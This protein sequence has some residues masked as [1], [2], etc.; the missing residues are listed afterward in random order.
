MVKR[1]QLSLLLPFIALSSFSQTQNPAN[2]SDASALL[3]KVSERYKAYK[4]VTAEFKL[5]IE[6]PKLKPEESDK[7]YTDTL[8]GK[9]LLQGAKFNI[10]IKDQ[11]IICDG[12]NL[13]T[14]VP[15]NKEVQVNYFE[16][17][18]DVFSPSKIFSLYREGYLYQ[19]KEKKEVN[20]KSVTVIEMSPSNKK[21]SYFKMDV[22]IEDATLQVVESKVYQK[23]G[24]RYVYKLTKQYANLATHED[25]FTFDPKRYAGVKV[26]DLR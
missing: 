13:W 20:G 15:E 19:V 11:Q 9:V 5:I 12:K 4:N 26:V 22:S 21:A 1:L 25:S 18:D 8:T 3:R 17:S 14:Y 10:T 6:R 7:K 23:N 2:D 24:T 16:E